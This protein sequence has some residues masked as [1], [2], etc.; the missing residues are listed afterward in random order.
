MKRALL[1]ALA[2]AIALGACERAGSG[3]KTVELPVAK[4]TVHMIDPGAEPRALIRMHA[5]PGAK[6]TFVATVSGE[7]DQPRR[8]PMP[9]QTFTYETEIVDVSG[10]G[11]MHMRQRVVAGS[12]AKAIGRVYES[13]IDA[14]SARVRPTLAT[15]G[16]DDAI[17]DGNEE[18]ELA[19]ISPDEAVGVG[20]R[21][22]EDATIGKQVAS[23]DVELLS[24]DGDRLRERLTFHVDGEIR[25]SPARRDGTVIEELALTDPDG[26]MHRNETFT[27]DFPQGGAHGTRTADIVEKP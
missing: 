9:S 21:W 8:A 2:L 3:E 23:V 25:G 16:A 20:A 24:R 6:A 27:I 22:H 13:W 7:F 10:D 5:K 12:I 14:R 17:P 1:V 15:L 18:P 11:V 19:L 26:S 4:V